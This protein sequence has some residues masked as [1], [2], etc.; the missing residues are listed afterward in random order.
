MDGNGDLH[1][2]DKAIEEQLCDCC[3]NIKFVNGILNSS[4]ASRKG[5]YNKSM[6]ATRHTNS[7]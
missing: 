2:E 7:T 1:D 6:P 5:I 3:D 4:W